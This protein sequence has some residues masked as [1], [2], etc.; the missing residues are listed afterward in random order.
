MPLIALLIH[1]CVTQI[2]TVYTWQNYSYR[3]IMKRAL[4]PNIISPSKRSEVQEYN[5]TDIFSNKFIE[6]NLLYDA[7]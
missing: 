1:A 6:L 7:G 4:T 3:I 2:Q 5:I